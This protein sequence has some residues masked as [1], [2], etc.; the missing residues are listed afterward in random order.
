[1]SFPLFCTDFLSSSTR[2]ISTLPGSIL[3]AII[4]WPL[5]CYIIYQRFW[6]PLASYPG[7]WIASCT[8]VWKAYYVY[9]L[10][11]HEKMVEAHQ[12][13]GSVVRVGPNHLHFWSADAIAPIYKAGKSVGKTE[14]YDAFTTF[15]PNLFGGRDE[16][17]HAKRRR[18]LSHAFSQASIE[19]M[20][21]IIDG[22]I[23]ILIHHL[24]GL[25][26]SGDAFDLKT[27]IA[28]FVLDILGEVAFSRTFNAQVTGGAGEI[29]AINDHV[30]LSCVIGELPCQ[31][32]L[33]TLVA[34]SPF[35]WIR[36]LLKSRAHLK[37]T[38]E[39]CVKHNLE[40]RS[41]RPDLLASLIIATDPETGEKLTDIAGSHSTSGTLTLLL[42]RL[43]H[44]PDI[45]ANVVQELDEALGPLPQGKIAYPVKG[46]D[47]RL[48]YLSACIRENFR[49][50]PVFSMNLWRQVHSL[51]GAQIGGHMV[52][53]GTNVC[54]SN[55][56]THHNPEIW[57]QDH[58]VYKPDRFIN[59]DGSNQDRYLLHFSVGHRMC[60]GRNLA[61]TNILKTTT[62]ILS[63]F[64]IEPLSKDPEVRLRS[65]GIGEM[66]G[67]FWCR[68]KT[69]V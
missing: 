27:I 69:K 54:I 9:N 42:W 48:T 60:I 66:E 43:L 14:F 12:R 29:E 64:E 16:A 34:W 61:M 25:A 67:K 40:N 50:N 31:G 53:H 19:R 46:L 38:C 33:K 57:G 51:E 21:D 22:Q 6:H 62:T 30:Y 55:Y 26:K 23:E 35:P 3:A 45:L 47:A 2:I 37:S 20:E 32:L 1:M 10:A 18:Q 65:A 44:N 68:I 36:R 15:N 63:M 41:Q 59:T 24:K 17:I 8:N 52:P 5:C 28:C 58:D 39:D 56:V 13:Y 49:I 4:L 7:P 11:F